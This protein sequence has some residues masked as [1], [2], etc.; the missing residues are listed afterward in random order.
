M[1]EMWTI[2]HEA[3]QGRRHGLHLH[4]AQNDKGDKAGVGHDGQSGG[5]GGPAPL[6]QQRHQQKEHAEHRYPQSGQGLQPLLPA[7]GEE[8][9]GKQRPEGP[10]P[11]VPGIVVH[12]DAVDP[13]FYRVDGDGQLHALPG[14]YVVKGAEVVGDLDGFPGVAAGENFQLQL[15]GAAKDVLRLRVLLGVVRQDGQHPGGLVGDA[16][17]V[18]VVD[19]AALP[20]V[21]KQRQKQQQGKSHG[22]VLDKGGASGVFGRELVFFGMVNLHSAASPFCVE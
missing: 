20:R 15:L 1:P 11:Q 6:D 18:P 16:G 12:A 7:H 2:L 14:N 19:G 10:D 4:A 21:K 22:G 8:R 3:A 13:L 17:A 5:N 9:Q